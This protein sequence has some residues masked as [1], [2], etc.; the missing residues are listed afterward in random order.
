[1]YYHKGENKY[2]QLGVQFQI[3]EITYP[4][5][6]LMQST[7]KQRDDIGLVEVTQSN[8]PADSFYYSVTEIM[9]G[10]VKTFVNTPKDLDYI[11]NICAKRINDSAYSQLHETDWVILKSFETGT[12]I[13]ADIKAKRDS[14]RQYSNK[15]IDSIKKAKTVEKVESIMNQLTWIL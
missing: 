10:G 4:S 8:S 12:E 1:M 6:W 9:E 3:G 11:K 13:P 7:K 15:T 5:I 14:I 2:I